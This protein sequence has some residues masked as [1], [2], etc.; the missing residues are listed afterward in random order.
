MMMKETYER[1]AEEIRAADAIIIGASNGLSITEGFHLFADNAW[2][3]AHFGDF[4]ARYGW[5]RIL[6]GM[7]WQFA[8]AEEQW[9]FWSRLANL[10]TYA[11]PVSPVMNQLRALTSGTPT[12][13]LTSNGED[14]FVPAGFAAE[15]VFEMEGTFT[16][17]RCARGCTDAVWSNREEMLRLAAA[18]QE[19]HVPPELVPRCPHCGGPVE[20][21]MASSQA[22]FR[23]PRW[24]AKAQDFERFVQ[25]AKGKRLLVLELGI[26]WRNQL[27]KAPLMRLVEATPDARYVTFNKGEVYIPPGI[28]DRSIGV[29]GDLGEAI[30]GV[31]AA[32]QRHA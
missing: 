1:I 21:D 27:I 10:V 18:E 31:F 22:F 26:G 14:H 3:Q 15:M 4:R 16:H 9:G 2:F 23:T 6:D 8:T 13:V 17:N 20:V 30:D 25:A 19:G 12:F 29:D 28:A 7:F 5:R 32:W 11:Q 24:Q